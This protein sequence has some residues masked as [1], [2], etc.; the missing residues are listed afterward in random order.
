M[1]YFELSWD[2][3]ETEL[4]PG[5][6]KGIPGIRGQEENGE[7]R[8]EVEFLNRKLQEYEKRGPRGSMVRHVVV[9]VEE[10]SKLLNCTG[11][12]LSGM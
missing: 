3:S 12:N 11:P 8:R 4:P 2:T 6:G 9:D 7:I 1:L 5:G 10:I